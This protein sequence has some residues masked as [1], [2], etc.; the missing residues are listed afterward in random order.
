MFC[1][2]LTAR[3][4]DGLTRDS[5]RAAHKVRIS[6]EGP[7]RRNGSGRRCERRARGDGAHGTRCQK[8]KLLD[9]CTLA[10]T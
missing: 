9:V 3:R 5:Y 4:F 10:L 7:V 2:A 1:I 6:R 8:Q